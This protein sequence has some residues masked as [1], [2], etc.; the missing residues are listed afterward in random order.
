[1]RGGEDPASAGAQHPRDLDHHPGGVGDEG[2]GP[3]GRARQVEGGRGEGQ[4]T[5]VGLD[6]RHGS[7]CAGVQPAGVPQLLG[8]EVDGHDVGAPADQPARALRG[9]AADLQHP[10]PRDLAKQPGVGLNFPLNSLAKHEE[11]TLND[12]DAFCT[13]VLL[14]RLNDG[15]EV[16]DL[17]LKLPVLV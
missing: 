9:T 15:S 11:E 3:E 4:R 16:E 8:G 1:M 10:A 7:P 14:P 6:E 5:G 2:H 17:A 12:I 13:E